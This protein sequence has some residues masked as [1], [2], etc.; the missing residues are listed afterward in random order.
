MVRMMLVMVR[1]IRSALT[2]G[3][4]PQRPQLHAKREK[5]GTRCGVIKVPLVVALKTSDG[6][7]KLSQHPRE[8]VRLGGE[9]V[10]L[11]TEWKCPHVEREVI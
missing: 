8:E 10:R 11:T 6:A 1:I 4:R 9:D 3:V 7:T 5:E 2:G